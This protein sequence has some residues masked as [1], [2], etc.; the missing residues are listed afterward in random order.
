MQV[1]ICYSVPVFPVR[2]NQSA[3]PLSAEIQQSLVL[4]AEALSAVW[5][6]GVK[7]KEKKALPMRTIALD[8]NENTYIKAAENV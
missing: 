3:V 8:G 6:S 4:L 5:L 7:K 2:P 1:G